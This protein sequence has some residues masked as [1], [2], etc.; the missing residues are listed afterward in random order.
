MRGG[1][2]VKKN[3]NNNNAKRAL[4]PLFKLLPIFEDN[5]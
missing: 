1:E 3:N 5:N 2:G 4:T